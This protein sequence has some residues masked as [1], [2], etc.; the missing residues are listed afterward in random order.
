MA[1]ASLAC[2][3]C[4][5]EDASGDA[6]VR[7]ARGH[8]LCGACFTSHV[9]VESAK[10]VSELQA[11][12]GE[13]RCPMSSAAIAAG[14]RCDAECY[15]SS[16]IASRAGKGAFDA[17]LS[18][19]MR[20]MEA[21]VVEDAEARLRRERERMKSEAGADERLRVAREDVIERVFTCACP[22][23]TQAFVDFSG[24]FALTC[25]RCGAGICAY[26]L[27][28]CGKDAHAHIGQCSIAK[29]VAKW[30]AKHDK[31]KARQMQATNRGH[32]VGTFGT[33]DMFSRAQRLRRIRH[34]A[35]RSATWDDDFF[36]RVLASLE[37]ELKDLGIAPNE[38][39]KE[40]GAVVKKNKA[41]P[42]KK[43]AP[44]A[45]APRGRNREAAGPAVPFPEIPDDDPDFF[46][47][48]GG[49]LG[50][51]R[52]FGVHAG[53]FNAA[54]AAYFER[55]AQEQLDR[56][57]EE[58][59]NRVRIQERARQMQQRR[60]AMRKEEQRIREEREKARRERQNRAREIERALL[61]D[62]HLGPVDMTKDQQKLQ[63]SLR[64]KEQRDMELAIRLSMETAAKERNQERA[65]R[66]G[67]GARRQ[68]GPAMGSP[69]RIAREGKKVVIVEDENQKSDSRS[70]KKSKVAVIDLT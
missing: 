26:C 23:C 69:A 24:C 43:A 3:V 52:R 49:A 54:A 18:G 5:D 44:K 45:P 39:A 16:V 8:A 65:R 60:E 41:H 38:I 56:A 57:A 50:L 28:D 36:N 12:D 42:Q 11:R 6:H 64:E 33:S 62:D 1:R 61:G 34:F 9:A 66:Q 7:C 14:E 67:E 59:A 29:D 27:T 15:D 10:D 46:P 40:R 70:S 25:A 21:R 68:A 31:E 48:M 20:V 51:L 58:E 47:E 63:K 2:V 22:R 53:A 55:E 35:A 4:G 19:K 37:V 32:A 17:Y 30:Q 13:V